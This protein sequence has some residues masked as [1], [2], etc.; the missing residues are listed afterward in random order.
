MGQHVFGIELGQVLTAATT[1][2]EDAQEL[3]S[4]A[5]CIHDG[6]PESAFFAGGRTAS[7]AIDGARRVGDAVKGEGTV[8]DVVGTDLRSFVRAVDDTEMTSGAMFSG[9]GC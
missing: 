1:L 7:A 6:A 5:S 9:G 2:K 3:T 8:V 4:A